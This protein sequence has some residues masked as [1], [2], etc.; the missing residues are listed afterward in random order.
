MTQN[1]ITRHLE[2][3]IR[4]EATAAYCISIAYESSIRN[5]M[6]NPQ[7]VLKVTNCFGCSH[8]KVIAEAKIVK[9]R[10]NAENVAELLMF[11]D[12]HSCALLQEAAL[13]LCLANPVTIWGSEG[14]DQLK[15]L[16]MLLAEHFLGA[17]PT[18]F[19]ETNYETMR[20]TTLCKKLDEKQGLGSR[21]HS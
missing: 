3:L 11:A 17:S 14:W 1:V 19:S 12:A 9:A 16:P 8:L 7:V 20:V 6:D 2:M 4:G 21:Q 5:N 18:K 10:I 13:K 15:E